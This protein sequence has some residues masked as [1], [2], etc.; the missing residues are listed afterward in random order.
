M[1]E[2]MLSQFMSPGA[3][4]A[5]PT[6]GPPMGP[7]SV[8]SVPNYSIP[9]LEQPQPDEMVVK[10]VQ[11]S[12]KAGEADRSKHSG[13]W[14]DF[15]R[16]FNG[17]FYQKQ[18]RGFECRP[19]K[20]KEFVDNQANVLTQTPFHD[21]CV[22]LD[23]DDQD[24]MCDIHTRVIADDKRRANYNE[25]EMRMLQF[26]GIFGPGLMKVFYDRSL[27]SGKGGTN[28]LE[29]D[30]RYFGVNPGC[31]S[32]PDAT[33]CF[34]KRPAPLSEIKHSYPD[35]AAKLKGDPA[36]SYE[37]QYGNDIMF[38]TDSAVSDSITGATAY[39][40][41]LKKNSFAANEANV[42]GE[43][44]YLTEFFF[45]DPRTIQLN[46]PDELRQ[47]V[48][49]RPG[50]GGK[51]PRFYERAIAEYSRKPFPLV[52][53]LYPHGR[54]IYTAGDQKLDD[55]PNPYCE[56]P[57]KWFPN[58]SKPDIFWPFGEVELISEPMGNYHLI[59]ST[60][61]AL[62]TMRNMPPWWC[63]DQTADTTKFKQ[64][65]P[66]E[67]FL[68]KNGSQIQ[69]FSIPQVLP[70]DSNNLLELCESE[71]E[72]A[73]ML[74]S[75]M[76]GARQT[77][78]Y[79][80]RL[81]DQMFDAALQGIKNV[82]NSMTEFRIQVGAMTLW[83]DQCYDDQQRILDFMND[84]D[85]AE[86]AKI[87]QPSVDMSGQVPQISREND[88]GAGVYGYRIED[89]TAMPVNKLARFNQANQIATLM[90]QC[91]QPVQALKLVLQSS[92][93]P[94]ARRILNE[95]EASMQGLTQQQ[96]QQQAQA[97][98]QA[99]LAQQQGQQT[100]A[101]KLATKIE[102]AKIG[103]AAGTPSA[104][105]E[106]PDPGD[107]I[108]SFHAITQRLL[109]EGIPVQ[110]LQSIM[111]SVAQENPMQTPPSNGMQPPQMGAQIPEAPALG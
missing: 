45:K 40:N 73:T 58:W 66:N 84:S 74:N 32:L 105:A 76:T 71:A 35:K 94:G 95:I 19:N 24:V 59:R 2:S 53:P 102:V 107:V 67:L 61:A 14:E 36:I 55:I 22:R 90:I 96:Q 6:S 34:Y 82:I 44:V 91:Q 51:N 60:A 57:F 108:E 77:G 52:V 99:L 21:Y 75:I 78:V 69:P 81:Y 16:K 50:F 68:I 8:N 93:F 26:A 20:Y 88:L 92:G 31:K 37:N 87:N 11:S 10:L 4:R 43:Q 86:L 15:R 9:S 39:F 27:A 101:A 18:K 109:A 97:A 54:I 28:Y 79:G 25:K 62:A 65:G 80:G 5:N 23:E 103:A 48:Y 13:Y 89:G 17:E 47:W 38:R 104:M 83:I 100:E 111:A 33:F 46:N 49:S 42:A 64:L 41:M 85:K 3:D 30:P 7:V 72:K 56:N 70:Q 63:S 98:A 110:E 1:A 29:I 106:S 12:V